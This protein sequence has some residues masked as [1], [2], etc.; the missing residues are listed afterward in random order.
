ALRH[1]QV[2]RSRPGSGR[3]R[4][5]TSYPESSYHG[6]ARLRDPQKKFIRHLRHIPTFHATF[7]VSR[8]RGPSGTPGPARLAGPTSSGSS[9]ETPNP[10]RGGDGKPL[11][12][13]R[14]DEG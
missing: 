3:R 4:A 9:H 13:L 14:R 1:D 11:G 7:V 2:L 8:C 12:L 6:P 10:S 5:A